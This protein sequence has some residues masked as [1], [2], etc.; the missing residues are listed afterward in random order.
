METCYLCE[1]VAVS[2]EHVPPKCLFPKDKLSSKGLGYRQ[3]LIKVPSCD[4]HNSLKSKDDEYLLFLLVTGM[5][6]NDNKEHLFT[7]KTLKAINRKPHVY[8]SFMKDLKPTLIKNKLGNV[9]E[10]ATFTVDLKR[11]DSVI[12]HIACGIYFHHLGEKWFK[13]SKVISN[14]L[15]DLSEGNQSINDENEAVFATLRKGFEILPSHGDNPEI[16]K[17]KFYS[18]NTDKHLIHMTFYEGIE[19]TVLLV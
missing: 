10:T 15:I 13:N 1:R 6:D 7:N 8:E 17:Y 14:A 3:N 2:K 18:K 12:H 19:V 16:F 9:Y 5:Y 11:F 4:V